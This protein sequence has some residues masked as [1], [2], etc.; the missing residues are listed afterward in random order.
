MDITDIGWL[1]S[2]IPDKWRPWLSI[3]L[4]IVF[5]VTKAR[6]MK[7]SQVIAALTTPSTDP[8]AKDIAK[9]HMFF[10]MAELLF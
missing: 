2:F 4:L 10:R 3:L 5:V 7:K 6:S 1:F 9:K 8:V